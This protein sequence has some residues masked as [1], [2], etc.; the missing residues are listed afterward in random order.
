M[1]NTHTVPALLLSS[2]LL[3]QLTMKGSIQLSGTT[4]VTDYRKSTHKDTNIVKRLQI[5]RTEWMVFSMEVLIC[6]HS[7][8]CIS[9][10]LLNSD[11]KSQS[12]P[13]WPR[14]LPP[15]QLYRILELSSFNNRYHTFLAF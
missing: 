2:I 4:S 12:L 3:P 1:H 14:P 9:N 11:Y 6:R 15:L 7:F 8:V 5:S 13:L 10:F